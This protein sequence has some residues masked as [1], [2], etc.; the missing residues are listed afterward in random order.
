MSGV[1]ISPDGRLVATASWDG[2]TKLWEIK[3]EREALRLPK[4]RQNYS[5]VA[6]SPDGRRLAVGSEG[7]IRILDT[8]TGQEVAALKG[9][10]ASVI[11]FL[12][13]GN[14]LVSANREELFVWR[15]A[16]MAEIKAGQ[17]TT[18]EEN[19]K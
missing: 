12:S 18:E 6:F 1:A 13:D 9:H 16:A 11:A 17:R 4:A 15:A 19:P 8:V 3:T 7:P 2:M 5:S 14:T 10:Q